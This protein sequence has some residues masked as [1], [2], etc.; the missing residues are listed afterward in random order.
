MSEQMEV[1]SRRKLRSKEEAKTIDSSLFNFEDDPQVIDP[2][3]P[4][5]CVGHCS[6]EVLKLEVEVPFKSPVVS[7]HI[8]EAKNTKSGRRSLRA[9][10]QAKKFTS[11]PL[12]DT[13]YELYHRRMEKEEKKMLNRDRESFCSEADKLKWQLDALL[14]NDWAKSL[15]SITFIRDTRDQEELQ[16]KREWTISSIRQL[17]EKYEDWK[18]REDRVL[19]KVRAHL[20]TPNVGNGHGQT[21]NNGIDFRFYT[22]SLNKF[23]YI[24]DSGTDSEEED[25]DVE[26]IKQRR[27]IKNCG[28]FGPSI[29]INLGHNNQLIAQPFQKTRI[30]NS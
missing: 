9:S 30:E 16:Q 28:K 3:E 8:Q 13:L 17:L 2:D 1:E 25:M 29:R 7:D 15:P 22:E 24:G 4:I 20:L 5:S 21:H 27:K 14:Q 26:E 23:D 19:G 12:D 11:D 18:R 10:T 6:G